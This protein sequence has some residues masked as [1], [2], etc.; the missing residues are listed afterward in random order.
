VAAGARAISNGLTIPGF[1][2]RY[3]DRLRTSVSACRPAAPSPNPGG[4]GD[5]AAG[6]RPVAPRP[7]DRRR[8]ARA[9]RRST[10]RWPR[11]ACTR[12]ARGR[13]P[14]H[15]VVDQRAAA[16]RCPPLGDG[17]GRALHR[18]LQARPGRPALDLGPEPTDVVDDRTLWWRHERLHRTVARDPDRLLPRYADDGDELEGAWFAD[19]AGSPGGVRRGRP[20]HRRVARAG[21][22][23]RGGPRPSAQLRPSLL[24]DP[25]PPRRPRPLPGWDRSGR[26]T[27]T[28]PADGAVSGGSPDDRLLP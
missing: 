14:D 6:P 27:R 20:S 7:R 2:D 11:R 1:A 9:T 17:H 16:R 24:A 3:A 25:R 8:P 22:G 23:G 12:G 4:G 28:S 15:R 26:L 10:A 19:A 21:P 5:L 13:L 18:D